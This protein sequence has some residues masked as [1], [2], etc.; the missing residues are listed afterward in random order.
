MNLRIL[1]CTLKGRIPDKED[2][3]ERRTK[4]DNDRTYGLN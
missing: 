4:R 3:I 1:E 2:S